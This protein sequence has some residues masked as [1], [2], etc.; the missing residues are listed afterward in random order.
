MRGFLLAHLQMRPGPFTVC[1]FKCYSVR[2]DVCGTPVCV[3]VC[4]CA[5]VCVCVCVCVC[6]RLVIEWIASTA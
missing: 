3:Y 5:C 1:V 4:V 6:Q 2:R